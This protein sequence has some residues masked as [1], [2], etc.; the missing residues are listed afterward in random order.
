MEK[1]KCTPPSFLGTDTSFEQAKKVPAFTLGYPKL[2]VHTQKV[3]V[4]TIRKREKEKD[5]SGLKVSPF[6]EVPSR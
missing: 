1:E 5:S 3:Y 2:L 6:V 4:A